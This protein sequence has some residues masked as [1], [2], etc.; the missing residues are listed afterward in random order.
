MI[1]LAE[2]KESTVLL[3]LNAI[4]FKGYWTIPFDKDLTKR[5]TFYLTSK[6]A[7][8]VPL[9]TAYNYFKLSTVESLN[10]RLISLP[11]QVKYDLMFL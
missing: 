6:T 2:T 5:G 10:A 7:I 9:M 1:I 3:L 4:Y 11:Y 8:D